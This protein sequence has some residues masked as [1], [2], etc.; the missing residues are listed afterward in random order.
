MVEEGSGDGAA[1]AVDVGIAG[2][3]REDLERSADME[4]L[5]GVDG[6]GVSLSADMLGTKRKT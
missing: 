6:S 4:R 5:D 1:E 2:R 3:S